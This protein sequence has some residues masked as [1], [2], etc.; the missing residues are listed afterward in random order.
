MGDGMAAAFASPVGAVAAAVDVQLA[1][2]EEAWGEVGALRAR[3]AL[4][5]GEGLLRSDGQYA[6]A[7]LNRCARLM[8]VAHGGQVVIS[9]AVEVLVRDGLAPEGGV[10][11]LGEHRL[12]YLA[13]PVRVFQVTHPALQQA[14]PPLRSLD[15]FP[16]NL[17]VQLTSFVGRQEELAG[18]AAALDDRR[19]VT[20]TGTG[21]VGKTRLAMQVA[22]H[23]LPR[24]RDGAWF[25][26]LAAAVD[27]ESMVQLVAATLGVS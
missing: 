20:V 19:L 1:L 4:H 22:A 9:D 2:R 11:D 23:V 25:C 21:G 12:R 15:V 10:V 5:V 24:F 26:E 14:F 8:S 6:N 18:V 27:D 7:P 17:P 3:M 16:G 13:L